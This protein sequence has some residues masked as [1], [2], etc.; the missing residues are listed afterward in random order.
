MNQLTADW[1][2]C[3]ERQR[4]FC[5][6]QYKYCPQLAKISALCEK[7]LLIVI[8]IDMP[9]MLLSVYNYI[10]KFRFIK[11]QYRKLEHRQYYVQRVGSQKDTMLRK[12][13]VIFNR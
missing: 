6:K 12:R 9:E 7:Y 4:A 11:V 2:N 1:Y 10:R 3:I 5:N 13:F 8:V